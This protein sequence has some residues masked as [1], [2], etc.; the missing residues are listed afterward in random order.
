MAAGGRYQFVKDEEK[1]TVERNLTAIAG[2]FDRNV[3]HQLNENE[4]V[5]LVNAQEQINAILAQRDSQ[6][7]V[8]ERRAPTG[9]HLQQSTCRTY[10][11]IEQER[12]DTQYMLR[13]AGASRESLKGN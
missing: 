1:Q 13:Q 2:L 12:A 4:K 5:E 9:S 3:G 11:Q 7:V 6:R 10:G 8:C